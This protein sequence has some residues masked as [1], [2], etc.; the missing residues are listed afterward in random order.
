MYSLNDAGGLI[1]EKEITI[2][3][4]KEEMSAI[5][6][7][8]ERPSVFVGSSSEGVTFAKAIQVVLDESCEVE[9]WSQGVF[10]LSEGTLE[11]LISALDRFDF[12]V[13]VLSAD[14]L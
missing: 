14:D 12:A 7:I 13:L 1:C 8:S 9:L 11:S 2:V 5:P 6:K 10:G 4:R 3:R